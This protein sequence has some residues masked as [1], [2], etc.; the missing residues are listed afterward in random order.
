[1]NMGSLLSA[2]VAV[3]T[4]SS[5]G[6]G[7]SMAQRFAREGAAVVISSRRQQASQQAAE[8][9]SRQGY[10]AAACA[11]DVADP[12][13][14]EAL[15]DY[16]VRTFGR[17]DIWVNNAALSS[18]YGPTLAIDP[19]EFE[20]VTRANIFGTYYGSMAALRR[21]TAQGSGKLINL[22]GRGDDR[23]APFQNAYASSKIWVVWFTRALVEETRNLGVEVHLLNPG[24]MFT[25]LVGEVQ[26]I[27]GFEDK[28]RPFETV[29][30]MWGRPPELAAERALWLASS[31]TDGRTG[32]YV[33]VLTPG[34]ILGGLLREGF[35]R[36][37]RRP[38]PRVDIH[39]ATV[40]KFT[41][42][43]PH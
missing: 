43:Q 20:R 1:M 7:L 26:A 23:P 6:L 32:Q 35:R 15:A 38:Q 10:S 25:D 14:V 36:L 19:R 37:F 9:L 29:L 17:L 42:D 30:R 5:R 4:G 2:K 27:E 33:K 13:Q 34:I 41:G 3:I 12:Q 16:A 21:F 28:L 31:A 24:L 22:V 40:P 18:A 11:C 39:I 8:N